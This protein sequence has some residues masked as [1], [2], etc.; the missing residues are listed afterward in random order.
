MQLLNKMAYFPAIY[1]QRN[2]TEYLNTGKNISV[3]GTVQSIHRVSAP[4]K[5]NVFSNISILLCAWHTWHHPILQ[6]G[7]LFLSFELYLLTLHIYTLGPKSFVTLLPWKL[8]AALEVINNYSMWWITMEV[9]VGDIFI[10]LPPVSQG[11]WIP[12][13]SIEWTLANGHCRIWEMLLQSVGLELSGP[14]DV[15]GWEE[16][17][18][19]KWDEHGM[20][21][22]ELES[23]VLNKVCCW[24]NPSVQLIMNPLFALL[25]AGT[26]MG[27]H[28]GW[29]S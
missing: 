3:L 13:L 4:W 22:E 10:L 14:C 15:T 12:P 24:K 21:C 9:M 28:Q 18:R 17:K 1:L 6:N 5:P 11:Q 8:A 19:E 2:S 29:Q 20:A 25:A 27:D 7:N 26:E 16:D 23:V